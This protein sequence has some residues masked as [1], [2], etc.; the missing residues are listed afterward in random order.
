MFPSRG[1]FTFFTVPACE[2]HDVHEMCYFLCILSWDAV[3]F[4]SFHGYMLWNALIV[5]SVAFPYYIHGHLLLDTLVSA[6]AH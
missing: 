5:I 4:F 1:L 2:C 6:N 3:R